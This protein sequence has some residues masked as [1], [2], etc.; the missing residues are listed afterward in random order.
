M[1]FR[2]LDRIWIAA[3]IGANHEGDLSVAEELVRKAAAAGAD[4]VKFQN[5]AAERYVSS[6]QQERQ[7]GARGRALEPDQFRRLAE[8]AKE[9]GVTFFSTPLAPEDAD[10]VDDFTPIFKVASGEITWTDHIRHLAGKNKPMIISTGGALL[11]EIRAAVDAVLEVRPD[12][13]DQGQLML[14]HCVMAYPVPPE[15]ANLRNIGMLQAEFGLPVGYSDHTLGN[16]TCELAIG[17]GAVAIEKHF[18]YRKENQE[19]RDHQ[20]SA[21]PQDMAELVKA[22][23]HAEVLLGRTDRSRQPAEEE[24]FDTMRRSVA[25]A[26]DIPADE[27]IQKEWLT[28]LRPL[29]GVPIEDIDTVVGKKA[30]RAIPTGDLIS[31]D[32]LGS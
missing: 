31:K 1:N 32:D 9:C 6:V 23:R 29:W 20:L 13:G 28:G 26:V 30:N 7:N 25:A 21:D 5:Y 15:S 22:I 10:L 4:S 27:V 2:K 19:F 12:A 16:T 24:I 11:D 18:T 14:M 3:E 17:A 8:V